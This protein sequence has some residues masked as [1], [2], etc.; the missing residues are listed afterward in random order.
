ME[1]GY[2]HFKKLIYFKF[3]SNN[4]KLIYFK[5]FHSYFNSNNVDAY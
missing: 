5:V 4:L 2:F 3:N 1:C